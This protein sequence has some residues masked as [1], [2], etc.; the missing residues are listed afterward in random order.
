MS[1]L[2]QKSVWTAWLATISINLNVLFPGRW[3]FVMHGIEVPPRTKSWWR[4][5]THLAHFSQVSSCFCLWSLLSSCYSVPSKRHALWFPS[6][7]S[8]Q[9]TN[10]GRKPKYKVPPA[11]SLF[12]RENSPGHTWLICFHAYVSPLQVRYCLSIRIAP[13]HL[14]QPM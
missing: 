4:Y 14:R 6:G 10:W 9:N 5:D 3:H 13:I 7:R 12:K 11:Y 8:E 2:P 1:R